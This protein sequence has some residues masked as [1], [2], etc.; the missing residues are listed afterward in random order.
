MTTRPLL[1]RRHLLRSVPAAFAIGGFVSVPAFAQAT[2]EAAA[3]KPTQKQTQT[4][5]IDASTDPRLAPRVI[6]NPAAKVLVQEWFSLTCTHCAHFALTEF[7]KIKRDF[8]D[9]GKIRFQ[10][11]DFP[12]DRIALVASMV[13]RSLPADRYLTFIDSLFSRQMKWAFSGGNPMEHLQQEAALA[14]ISAAQFESISN[15][16]PFAEAL[17]KQAQ[18]AAALYNIQGTPYFRFN[19]IALPQAPESFEQFAEYVKKA[20]G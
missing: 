7:P 17:Y 12:L 1:A 18:K 10:F 19:D 15:D 20:A 11:N 2:G 6:G 16:K 8:I 13:A 3:Q 14:G 5:T 4:Q 9:T